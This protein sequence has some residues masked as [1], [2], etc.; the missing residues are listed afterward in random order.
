MELIKKIKKV[1]E[2]CFRYSCPYCGYDFGIIE[3]ADYYFERV[4]GPTCID[5]DKEFEVE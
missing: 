1:K 5:C 2:E 4:V 3:D